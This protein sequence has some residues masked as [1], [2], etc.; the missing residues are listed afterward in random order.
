MKLQTSNNWGAILFILMLATGGICAQNSLYR[1]DN[2]WIENPDKIYEDML[3]VT[4]R[5]AKAKAVTLDN[6]LEQGEVGREAN[7]FGN[8][9]LLNGKPLEYADFSIFSK[10]ILTVVEGD[11][12]SPVAKKIPFKIYLRRD[13]TIIT[14]GKSDINREITE[15]EISKVLSLAR[16]GDHLII[17]PARKSDWKAKRI[18]KVIMD[19]C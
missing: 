11:P 17:A 1:I 13:G 18:I 10:G 16:N 8:P 9:L 19:G 6:E 12:E 5:V 14:Q 2:K 15:I 7:F 3:N 4:D